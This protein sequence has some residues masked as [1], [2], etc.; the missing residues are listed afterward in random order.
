M[1]HGVLVKI[2][3]ILQNFLLNETT[4]PVWSLTETSKNKVILCVDIDSRDWFTHSLS[5]WFEVPD[6]NVWTDRLQ[7]SVF[8]KEYDHLQL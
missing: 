2:N 5:S 6:L 3:L 7:A 8:V 4:N 1:A